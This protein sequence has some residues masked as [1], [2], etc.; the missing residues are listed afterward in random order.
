[1]DGVIEANKSTNQIK[2]VT[3]KT[4]PVILHVFKAYKFFLHLVREN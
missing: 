1:M 4:C 2:D 3:N